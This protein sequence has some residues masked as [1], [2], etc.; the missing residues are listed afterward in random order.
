LCKRGYNLTIK[1]PVK[2]SVKS[3]GIIL[4]VAFI[5]LTP[6]YSVAQSSQQGTE[7]SINGNDPVSIPWRIR[8]NKL[9][10]SDTGLMYQMGLRLSNSEN[11]RSQ[12]VDAFGTVKSFQPL[13]ATIDRQYRY[14]DI[15]ALAKNVGWRWQVT[16]NRL[17]VTTAKTEISTVSANGLGTDRA[18][19]QVDT[20]AV[21]PWR[22]SQDATAGFLTIYTAAKPSLIQAPVAPGTVPGSIE[23][24]DDQNITNTSFKV[25][26]KDQKTVIQF[27]IKL[28]SRARAIGTGKGIKIEISP[29]AMAEW[30]I[31]WAPGII[32]QQKWQGSAGQQ[33]PL[34]ILELDPQKVSL[35]PIL[36]QANVVGSSP[37]GDIATSNGAAA[38]INGGYFN[39][40]TRQPLGAIKVNG[41]WLSSPILGRAALGWQEKGGWQ[42]GRLSYS[43]KIASSRGQVVNNLLNSGLSQGSVGRYSIDWG[44]TYQ[45]LTNNEL[46]LTIQ[47]GVQGGKV[48]QVTSGGAASAAVTVPI[49][50]D[51]Y[52]LIGRGGA[53][54]DWAV[55]TTVQIA[56]NSN[57]A[58]FDRLPN[59]LG[60]GPWL[61]Q[62]RQVVLDTT[63]EKFGSGFG[64]QSVA[65]RSAIAMNAQGKLWVIGALD[66]VGGKGPTLGELAKMLQEM[67]AVD[68]LNL[69]G[70]SSTSL[71]LG[72]QLV[73]RSP[74]TTAKVNNGLGIFLNV[75]GN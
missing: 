74:A 18:E 27:P 22:L 28:G 39:R 33:F 21:V 12:P 59:V 56:A 71:F 31:A 60:A 75:A 65:A 24:G 3:F 11:Y 44:N 6:S 41:K 4:F 38:A 7:V 53:L 23:P 45:T 32:W 42:I 72:G 17:Q 68:A 14:L 30:K 2:N 19:I 52:L 63:M 13:A 35:R 25:T 73:N 61:V 58:G 10:L 16:A 54:A 9:Q 46:I 50:R 66:R 49:P 64:P 70:G 36:G 40:I 67:G 1:I 51:G 69:D 37:I 8:S 62:Q 57:P 47:G 43:E 55:G 29:T 15:T 48:Q 26:G 5:F 34:S 20:G